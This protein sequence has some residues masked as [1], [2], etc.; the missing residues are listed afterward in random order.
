MQIN[1]AEVFCD[2]MI[3]NQKGAQGGTIQTEFI[4]TCSYELT[5]FLF[6]TRKVLSYFD[7]CER[8]PYLAPF[9]FVSFC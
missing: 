5:F 6:I 8:L 3:T 2:P 9:V 7:L 4:F 1:E